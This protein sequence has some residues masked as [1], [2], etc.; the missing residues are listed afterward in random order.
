MARILRHTLVLA[1]PD[2]ERSSR[3]Y[4]EVLGFEVRALAPGWLLYVRDACYVMAGE[5]PDALPARAIGDHS[6]VGHL[7]VDRV[8]EDHR[9][10]IAAGAEIIKPIRDE[11]WGMREFGVRTADGHR[12]MIGSVLDPAPA[13]APSSS[14]VEQFGHIDIYLFDQL[15][16]GRLGPG[17]RVLD[18]GCGTGRNLVYLLRQGFDVSATDENPDAVASSRALAA[19]LAPHLPAEQFRAEAVEACSF[20]D[21]A[22]DVVISSAVLHFARDD[23]QFDAMVAA[24][25]RVLKPGGLLFCRLASSI[26]LRGAEPLGNRRYLLPDGSE[27][28]LVDV[29]RLLAKTHELGGTLLDPLKTTVVQD[30]RSMTTWVVGKPLAAPGGCPDAASHR[31][32]GSAP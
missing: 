18:A 31:P 4:R 2:L 26:G 19:S 12:L 1:V 29:D 15:L 27:R 6:Y 22:F 10:A 9:R 11:P 23:A 13:A 3:F 28:Y 5:C 7:T 24:M 17:M 30:Q 25:W 8:D 21:A 16:R 14:I 32:A 20:A